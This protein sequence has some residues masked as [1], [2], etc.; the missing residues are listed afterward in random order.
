MGLAI[1]KRTRR[2]EFGAALTESYTAE[3]KWLWGLVAAVVAGALRYLHYMG[4]W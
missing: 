3:R 1:A 4:A 2:Q